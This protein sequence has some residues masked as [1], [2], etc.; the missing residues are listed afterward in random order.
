MSVLAVK[1]RP[2][3]SRMAAVGA[4]LALAGAALFTA[5]PAQAAL[6]KCNLDYYSATNTVS[7][8]CWGTNWS[9]FKLKFTCYKA[10]A[11]E[12]TWT[13]SSPT[14]GTSTLGGASFSWKVGQACDFTHQWKV[15]AVNL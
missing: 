1:K 9:S 15:E 5:A 4:V 14:Y 7:G 13:R 8:T 6:T 2:I 3:R 11:W 12:T 10:Y